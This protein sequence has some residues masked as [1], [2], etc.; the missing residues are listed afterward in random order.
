MSAIAISNGAASSSNATTIGAMSS[1]T[2]VAIG[3]ASNNGAPTINSNGK[4]NSDSDSK[5]NDAAWGKKD[6]HTR[7]RNGCQECKARKVK[8]DEAKPICG[9]CDKKKLTCSYHKELK[10][11]FE[12]SGS[13]V[14]EPPRKRARRASPGAATAASTIDAPTIDT[15]TN[16]TT[17]ATTT[18]SI[19]IAPEV[20]T[21]PAPAAG[22]TAFFLAAGY[23][24][25]PAAPEREL[26]PYELMSLP[27]TAE[28]C[29]GYCTTT[30]GGASPPTLLESDD[31]MAVTGGDQ[32]LTSFNTRLPGALPAAFPTAQ[33]GAVM[34]WGAGSG[35]GVALGIQSG[36]LRALGGFHGDAAAP[37]YQ[38]QCYTTTGQQQLYPTSSLTSFPWP[39]A[40]QYPTQPHWMAAV[41][42]DLQQNPSPP[43]VMVAAEGGF[44]QN[45][46]LLTPDPSFQVGLAF[47]PS[48][49]MDQEPYLLSPDPS[50]LA[51]TPLWMEQ[52]LHQQPYHPPSFA[53]APPSF[54]RGAAPDMSW[55]TALEDTVWS[56]PLAASPFVGAAS[57][58][59]A[60]EQYS[61]QFPPPPMDPTAVASSVP[62]Q[63][64]FRSWLEEIFRTPPPSSSA[65]HLSMAGPSPQVRQYDNAPPPPASPSATLNLAD[66]IPLAHDPSVSQCFHLPEYDG[67]AWAMGLVDDEEEEEAAGTPSPPPPPASHLPTPETTP[68]AQR[69]TDAAINT[70]PTTLSLV[71][72]V[73][74][75]HDPS[76]SQQ[77]LPPTEHDQVAEG[78]DKGK[79]KGKERER[80]GEEETLEWV[81]PDPGSLLEAVLRGDPPS[82]WMIGPP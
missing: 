18:A 9:N 2:A 60:P 54:A 8:C 44:W 23:G 79:G 10:F 33:G 56:P 77:Y 20:A 3:A 59:S 66:V 30:T 14:A 36:D 62:N 7:S 78:T 68:H 73:P 15:P 53:A 50:A 22:Q 47:V 17:T 43:E 5:S 82:V 65:P 37:A 4:R 35:L 24:V 51:H 12:A 69:Y 6:K 32:L 26:M 21:A 27:T 72:V 41:E 61:Q 67:A 80:K 76:A 81:H 11:V 25:A 74:P 28:P 55:A 39:T 48:P 75:T 40:T 71:D 63:D 13:V 1:N 58:P 70:S 52:G 42:R 34:D 45:P 64:S 16:T 31:W 19:A 29:E 49:M 57:G 38:E 46:R